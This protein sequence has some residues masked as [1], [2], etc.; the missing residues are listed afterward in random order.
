MALENRPQTEAEA[1]LEVSAL[2]AAGMSAA[3]DLKVY[4]NQVWILAG[5]SGSGKSQFLKSLADLIEHQ[6]LVRLSGTAQEEMCPEQWRAQVMYF[7]AETAW[8]EDTVAEHFE[9]LPAPEQL[10]MLGLDETMLQ[11]SPLSLSSG[12][13]QRLALLRGL[14]RAPRVLLLDEITANLDQEN[15]L[16]VEKLLSQYLAEHETG[17]SIVWISHDLAQHQRIGDASRV[18]KFHK[19]PLQQE[20]ASA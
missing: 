10:A 16:Q 11:A 1:L 2:S 6:G 20:G 9:T 7:A 8:W 5:P 3:I 17:A 14:S 15:A 4:A 13:K 19:A 12:E 18:I